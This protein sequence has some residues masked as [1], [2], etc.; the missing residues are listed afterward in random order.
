MLSIGQV[1]D[2]DTHKQWLC[3]NYSGKITFWPSQLQRHVI[4]G[5][6]DRN[7]PQVLPGCCI[8]VSKFICNPCRDLKDGLI[9]QLSAGRCSCVWVSNQIAVLE[10]DPRRG[11][12]Y[13]CK[14][15]GHKGNQAL[16]V[17]ETDASCHEVLDKCIKV[18]YTSADGCIQVQMD[19]IFVGRGHGGA[20]LTGVRPYLPGW[21]SLLGLAQVCDLGGD[22]PFIDLVHSPRAKGEYGACGKEHAASYT[23]R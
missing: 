2:W 13:L 22:F 8:S 9:P 15:N 19:L 20:A 10:P 16:G 18:A 11:K 5:T 23:A 3:Q 21:L 6:L 1:F 17:F 12:Q 14:S 7:V 4:L